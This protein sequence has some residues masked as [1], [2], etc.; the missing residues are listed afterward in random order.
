MGAAVTLGHRLRSPMGRREAA[1][2]RT[3]VARHLNVTAG[4]SQLSVFVVG[5]GPDGRASA[6]RGAA[7]GSR[8]M[9]RRPPVYPLCRC[10]LIDQN[11][12]W[13]D[14]PGALTTCPSQMPYQLPKIVF[15]EMVTV[16]G[17]A[18]DQTRMPVVA[19]SAGVVSGSPSRLFAP[20][21]LL[22]IWLP[23]T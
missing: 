20:M 8:R 5:L 22:R 18:A 15:P 21:R 13:A 16:M 11:V 1:T 7:P 9:R 10:E 12:L 14:A 3:R 17:V 4:R 19:M 23:P 2:P 6:P